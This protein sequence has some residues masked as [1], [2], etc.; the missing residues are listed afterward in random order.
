M[1]DRIVPQKRIIRTLA[2]LI[3]IAAMPVVSQGNASSGQLQQREEFH[4]VL[5]KI[6][7]SLDDITQD[8]S[9][10]R[11][12]FDG[13]DDQVFIGMYNDMY[14]KNTA[15]GAEKTLYRETTEKAAFISKFEAKYLIKTIDALTTTLDEFD[16]DLR[17]SRFNRLLY[18]DGFL[19]HFLNG[20]YYTIS[21]ARNSTTALPRSARVP[22]DLY[23]PS[24]T[25]AK[26]DMRV[27]AWRSSQENI[28]RLRIAG[29]EFE[30]ELKLFS[31]DL[32]KANDNE[33]VASRK[34]FDDAFVIFIRVYFNIKSSTATIGQYDK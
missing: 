27:T 4:V 6:S 5:P 8:F 19:P 32:S 25:S 14:I 13:S 18:L 20:F 12:T 2:F 30:H 23:D 21:A 29:K 17:K 24:L 7:I 16:E 9:G 22:E 34:E 26:S 28:I 10:T 1:P 33:D 31:K 15:H 3:A 11:I